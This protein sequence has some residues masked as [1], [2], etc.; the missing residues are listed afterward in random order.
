VR[1]PIR[2]RV[3]T[4][5]VERAQFLVKGKRRSEHGAALHAQEAPLHLQRHHLARQARGATPQ[6][7]HLDK[8]AIEC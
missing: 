4:S 5:E 1:S 6:R 8:I 7:L 2:I 3:R